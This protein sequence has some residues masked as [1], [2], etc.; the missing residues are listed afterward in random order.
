MQENGEGILVLHEDEPTAVEDMLR[1]IYTSEY[2][3]A[4][5]D[6]VG[7][8]DS[9]SRTWEDHLNAMIVADKYGLPTLEKVAFDHCKAEVASQ[10]KLAKEAGRA[11]S[12]ELIRSLIQRSWEYADNERRFNKLLASLP[13]ISGAR[14]TDLFE[15]AFFREWIDTNPDVAKPLIEKWFVSLMRKKSFR[16]K[17]SQDPELSLQQLDRLLQEQYKSYP[18]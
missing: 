17:I 14:F 7:G 13:E 5:K 2:P 16:D 12:D 6:S 10:D 18:Y 9:R 4:G 1:W 15:E 11:T 3:S 8:C